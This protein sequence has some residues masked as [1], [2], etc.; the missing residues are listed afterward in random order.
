MSDL[1]TSE[2]QILENLFGMEA[3]YVLDF[4]DRKI[5]EFFEDE[6]NINI[7]NKKYKYASGSKANRMRKFWKV[8]NNKIVGQS[9]LKLIDYINTQITLGVT[10]KDNFPEEKITLAKK[11]AKRLLGGKIDVQRKDV[12]VE[13]NIINEQINITLNPKIFSHVQGLLNN[14]HYYNAIEESYKIVRS[15][16]REITGKEKAHEAFKEDNYSLI[17]GH[18][19]KNEIENDFFEGVKFLHMAIQKL[20]NEKAHTPAMIV[21]KNLAIHYIVLASLAYD[22]I[23]KE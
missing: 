23:D 14:G 13:A 17:F 12:T 19:A 8:A 6:L 4:T 11:I 5:K 22:L 16:L 15:K 20:R 2:K 9:I 10:K 7:Y 21:D 3:G 1:Q 18:K